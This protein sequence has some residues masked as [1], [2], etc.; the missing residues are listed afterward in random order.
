MLVFKARM[1]TFDGA[2]VTELFHF[3]P[4]AFQDGLDH[5]FTPLTLLVLCFLYL[6][7]R[8]CLLS[9]RLRLFDGNI[10]VAL[11]MTRNEWWMQMSNDCI[12]CGYKRTERRRL[13]SSIS[14]IEDAT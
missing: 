8:R 9:Q 13:A 3:G 5:F 1:L 7:E 12:I 10:K 11:N 4:I 6:L 14:V 2:F